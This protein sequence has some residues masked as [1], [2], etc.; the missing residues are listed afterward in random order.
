MPGFDALVALLV[1]EP[2]RRLLV[3]LLDSQTIDIDERAGDDDIRRWEYEFRYLPPLEDA[4]VIRWDHETDTVTRGE[5]WR[6]IE[7][8][9]RLLDEHADEL[10]DDWLA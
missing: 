7:A 10:P 9:V 3:D 6:E 2:R 8:L 1:G 5:N 4:G